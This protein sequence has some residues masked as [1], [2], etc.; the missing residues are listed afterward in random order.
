L[1]VE[2]TDDARE[3]VRAASAWW[4]ENRRASPTLLEDELAVAVGMLERG[5]LLARV[6][7]SKRFGRTRDA[8][9]GKVTENAFVVFVVAATADQF[10]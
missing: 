4:R 2:F 7:R 1:S 6:A 8:Q 5:P 3:Q 9:D 10:E